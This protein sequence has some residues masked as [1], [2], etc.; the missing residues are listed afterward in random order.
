M[1]EYIYIYYIYLFQVFCWFH[2]T[3]RPLLTRKLQQSAHDRV[4]S[5]AC[6]QFLVDLWNDTTRRWDCFATVNMSQYR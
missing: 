6:L 4:R 2:F 5:N 1:H 3:R